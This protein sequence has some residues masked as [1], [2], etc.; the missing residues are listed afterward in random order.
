M[1]HKPGAEPLTV[2]SILLAKFILN[3][4]AA[5]EIL[6]SSLGQRMRISIYFLASVLSTALGLNGSS[7]ER[8][9]DK[10]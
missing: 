7:V 8:F 4:P 1:H 2:G 3:L 5:Q 10:C 9:I 6:P